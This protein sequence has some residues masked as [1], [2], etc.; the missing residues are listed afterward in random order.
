VRLYRSASAAAAVAL[1][2]GCG[3]EKTIPHSTLPRL[4]LQP[5][6]LAA[7]FVRFDTGSLAPRD[8]SPPRADADR[9]GRLGGWKA[10]FR[11]SG[12][13]TTRGPL[14]IQSTIDLF[15]SSGGAKD[16]LDAYRDQFDDVA[17]EAGGSLLSA[18]TIGRESIVLRQRQPGTPRDVV[19][20]TIAWRDRNAT[21]SVLVEGFEGRITPDDALRIARRQERRIE[22]AGLGVAQSFGG[23]SRCGTFRT[24]V[25]PLAPAART[26]S[27]LEHGS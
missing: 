13:A 1:L 2:A 11:R 18:P 20:I 3:G 9:F 8:M 17:R 25:L 4:V 15:R 14:V 16:D 10:R 7:V 24:A 26:K 6:D 19:F 23:H 27:S 21:A 22:A 5:A 12:F